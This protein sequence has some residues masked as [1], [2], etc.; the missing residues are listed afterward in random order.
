[1]IWIPGK[2]VPFM[3]TGSSRSG[4]RY[5]IPEYREWKEMAGWVMAAE[6]ERITSGAIEVDIT[7]QPDGLWVAV[8]KVDE[9]H[10]AF[11]RGLR[12]DLDNYGK[13][14]LDAA[15]GIMFTDDRQVVRL[16]ERFPAPNRQ[17]PPS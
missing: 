16:S 15:N 13:A 10:R 12:G 6:S 3:R 17:K 8:T 9:D 1:M 7:V 2:P 5:S 11:K 4:H 14:V